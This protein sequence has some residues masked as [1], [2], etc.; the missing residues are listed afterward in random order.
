MYNF[1]VLE[2]NHDGQLLYPTWSTLVFKRNILFFST[3]KG[4]ILTTRLPIAKQMQ[5]KIVDLAQ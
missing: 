1:K 2:L 5:Q 4:I 3:E